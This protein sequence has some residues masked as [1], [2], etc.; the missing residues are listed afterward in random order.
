MGT[1]PKGTSKKKKKKGT[2]KRYQLGIQDT[3]KRLAF[4]E[5][6]ISSSEEDKSPGI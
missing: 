3:S 5:E 1:G 2:S 4:R 6:N